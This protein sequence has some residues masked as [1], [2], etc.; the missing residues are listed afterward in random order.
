ML[1]R[2]VVVSYETIR[3]WCAKFR[4][5]YAIRLR[6]R[7][8]RPGEMAS[9]WGLHPHQRHDPLPVARGRPARQC[10]R[11]PGPATPKRGG[12]QKVL[13]QTAQGPA[14]R[15][16]GHRHRRVEQL[17]GR[18]PRNRAVGPAPPVEVSEQ[19]SRELPSTQPC[20][21]AGDEALQISQARATL[22]V[23]FLGHFTS[24]PSASASAVGD[25]MAP[26]MADR[27]TAWNQIT[28]VTTASA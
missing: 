9:R 19:S 4:Q 20:P 8:A 3:Q 11:H 27:F 28:G 17:P 16:A 6:R 1:Q 21:G 7:Q 18:A 2:G 23:R 25:R 15:T 24:F 26:R 13:P 12:R 22:P 5:V 10:A 14:I